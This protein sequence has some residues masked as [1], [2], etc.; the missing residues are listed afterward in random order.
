MAKPPK[1]IPGS[2][3]PELPTST[4][5]ITPDPATGPHVGIVHPV[6]GIAGTD[7]ISGSP[8]TDAQPG[9]S[10]PRPSVIVSQMPDSQIPSLTRPAVTET[11]TPD[12]PQT[13]PVP[14]GD[15]SVRVRPPH[16]VFVDSAVA[17]LL[18]NAPGTS[19]GIHYDKYKKAYVE[20]AGGM[21]MVR[22]GPD[23]YRQTHAQES[24]A[25][26]ERVEQVPG[27]KLWRQIDA[28]DTP[29]KRPGSP[30][31]QAPADSPQAT[32]GPSKR[33]RL[34]DENNVASDAGALVE[35]L[36]AQQSNALDLSISQWKNWGKSTKPL[37]GESIEIEGQHYLIVPQGLRPETGLVYMQHPGFAP[38][39]FDAFEHMLRHEPSRQPKWAL[40]RNGEWKVLDNHPP[41]AMSPSQYVASA[42]NYLSDAST[43]AIARAVFD[44]AKLPD[45]L[46]GHG[47]SVMALTFRHWMDRVNSELPMPSLA[48]PLVMLPRLPARP[49]SLAPGGVLTLPA[50]GSDLLQRLDFDPQRFPLEWG[51]YAAAPTGASLRN[52][53]TSI[54]QHNGYRVSPTTRQHRE[55]ALIFHR[56]GVAAVFVLKLPHISGDTVA[57]TTIIGSELTS[58]D[59]QSRL[60]ETDKQRLNDALTRNEIIHLVGGVHQFPREN[61]TLFIVREG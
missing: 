5:R 18:K 3:S 41:F 13:S 59:F 12:T 29:S 52:L 56:P 26:G 60:H 53:F 44:R 50:R 45:G 36:F 49:D 16:P 25:S 22:K 24:S 35:N 54:L 61:P 39:H 57:R 9:T 20:M 27:S 17:N 40:K 2:P 30:G 1:K 19:E 10:V 42:F 4:T 55:G 28:I 48:D 38:E 58:S 15:A 47:L 34:S 43:L 31:G 37:S 23:G 6:P 11:A 14:T 32:A 46:N 33:A 21:V 51:V 8:S 7:A